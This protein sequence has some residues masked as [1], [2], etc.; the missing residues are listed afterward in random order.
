M[1]RNA[2]RDWSRLNRGTPAAASVAR[3]D[4]L[5]RRVRVCYTRRRTVEL[6]SRD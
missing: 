3:E 2:L 1:H 6:I 4:G 5:V